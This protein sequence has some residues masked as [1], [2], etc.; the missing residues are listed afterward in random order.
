MFTIRRFARKGV[1]CY[2]LIDW[3][4]R[5]AITAHKTRVHSHFGKVRVLTA[6][7]SREPG[8]DDG[9][10]S[11]NGKQR[12]MRQA[13]ATAPSRETD[14]HA[15]PATGRARRDAEESRRLALISSAIEL[16]GEQGSLD[17]PVKTIAR[18]AGM[19]P[20][21]AFHYF[22]DKDSMLTEAMRYLL[23]E[24][25]RSMADGLAAAR[26]PAERLETVIETSFTP[27]QF[28]RKTIAAWLVFYLHAFSSPQAARLLRIYFSRL[29]SNL[30]SAL[31]DLAGD[32]QAAIEI[33]AQTGAMIDGIYIRQALGS[34]EPDSVRA[35]Q[36]CREQV[37]A[38]LKASREREA[39]A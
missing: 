28:D 39:L 34:C 18:H 5:H 10:G 36:M 16:I 21:L 29:N 19:S 2:C 13:S 30:V 26:S 31:K 32:G 25:T 9:P 22:G 3:S 12:T 33:A 37:A 4:I 7:G 14:A 27:E 8:G 20:A 38:A 24:L 35:R 6:Q 15:G 17:V 23:R 1:V 11:A